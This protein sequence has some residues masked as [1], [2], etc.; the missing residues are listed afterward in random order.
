MAGHLLIR[1]AARVAA[2]PA[3]EGQFAAP[4][5]QIIAHL[6]TF[7]SAKY[8][9]E[10]AYRN[11]ADRVRGPWRDSLVDHWHVHAKDERQSVYDLSMK[12]VGL[13]GDPIQTY[14]QVP[15][16]TNNVVGLMQV[17][18]AMELEAIEAGRGLVQL[19]GDNTGLRVLAENTVVLDTHHLDDLRRMATYLASPE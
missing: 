11:F 5:G 9:V 18:M 10:M 13:G 17:L 7:I 3:K 16:C 14:I 6:Q 2:L 19:S 15:A 1:I 8:A 12:V 4:E